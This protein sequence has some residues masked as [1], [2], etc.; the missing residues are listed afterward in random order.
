MRIKEV[1]EL[2]TSAVLAERERC[3]GIGENIPSLDDPGERTD[4]GVGWKAA[5]RWLAIEI[6]SANPPSIKVIRPE[7]A[8]LHPEKVTSETI[9]AG[10]GLVGD[11]IVDRKRMSI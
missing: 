8:K 4:Y 9:V 7:T 1:R 3:A 10:Q 2:I 11:E 6:R 5:G